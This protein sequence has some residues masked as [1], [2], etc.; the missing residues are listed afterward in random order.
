MLT[1]EEMMELEALEA[2]LGMGP[3]KTVASAPQRSPSAP[4]R[5]PS[6]LNIQV[7]PGLTP[8]EQE[9]LAMLE[10]E[11]AARPEYQAPGPK[12]GLLSQIGSLID[13]YSGAAATRSAIG[14]LQDTGDLRTAGSAFIDQY[15]A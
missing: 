14:A 10:T 13:Q 15:G 8:E 3:T 12:E 9:E 5:Q 2:E 7:L 1:R 4:A 6:D 11:F